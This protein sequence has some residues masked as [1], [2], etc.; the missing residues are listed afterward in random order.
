MQMSYE[1]WVGSRSQ[2]KELSVLT[3]AG[4][5]WDM[6]SGCSVYQLC[7]PLAFHTVYICY[8]DHFLMQ[9]EGHI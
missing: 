6:E 1:K 3:S 9:E 7:L 5:K 2:K 8:T 4:E